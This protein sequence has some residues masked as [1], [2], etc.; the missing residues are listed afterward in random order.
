MS[1]SDLPPS[2]DKAAKTR[3]LLRLF[4]NY[5]ARLAILALVGG[6]ALIATTVFS[7]VQRNVT[8][9]CELPRAFESA[10]MEVWHE[11]E[12]IAGA[13]EEGS[14][15]ALRFDLA[16]S[17]GSYVL[18]VRASEAQSFYEWSEDFDVPS[19]VMD[20]SHTFYFE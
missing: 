13:S 15:D 17:P 3:P 7:S 12:A 11:G 16:L 5:K 2:L 8:L 10:S 19:D 18:R 1:T 4:L 6:G 20:V 14:T 9:R